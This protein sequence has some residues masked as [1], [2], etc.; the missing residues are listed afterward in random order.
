[1]SPCLFAWLACYTLLITL[2][3]WSLLSA[4]QWALAELATPRS[5]GNWQVWREDV[6]EQQ[7]QAGPVRRRVP[8]SA[9]PPAL[10]LLRDYFGV[11]LVGAIVF[12][13]VL[14]W[15]VAWFVTGIF[16]SH[17]GAEVKRSR[18]VEE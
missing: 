15:I 2:V 5:I 1:L 6:R 18:G 17:S 4:R 12:S 10:V 9:E 13:T 7:S 11:S 16:T 14:F 3:I 8:K